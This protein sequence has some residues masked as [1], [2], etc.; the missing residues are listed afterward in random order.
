M[1]SIKRPAF[2]GWVLT[3][4]VFGGGVGWILP[5]AAVPPLGSGVGSSPVQSPPEISPAIP[6]PPA[7]S[8]APTAATAGSV[9]P[10]AASQAAAPT[11]GRSIRAE[12]LMLKL[13]QIMVH[14]M[15]HEYPGPHV[16]LRP[17]CVQL[18]FAAAHRCVLRTSAAHW[19][20]GNLQAA[21]GAKTGTR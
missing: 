9:R 4:I 19:L 7:A 2:V 13:L 6:V 16:R 12:D 17:I 11:D 15:P 20:H 18:G 1:I 10:L 8:W 14:A 3:G 21:H 5:T